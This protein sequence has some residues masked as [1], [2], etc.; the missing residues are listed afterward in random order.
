MAAKKKPEPKA[1]VEEAEPKQVHMRRGDANAYVS[2]EE[3]DTFIEAG[4]EK[5]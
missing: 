3:V 2:P 4:W 5:A 1:A